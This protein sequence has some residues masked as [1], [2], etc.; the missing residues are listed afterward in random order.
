MA[1]PSTKIVT[2]ENGIQY[3]YDAETSDGI[4]QL[5]L[6]PR[7]EFIIH[8]RT[9]CW[10]SSTVKM[11]V[12]SLFQRFFNLPKSEFV[13][14][15][16]DDGSN[17]AIIA[18]SRG[19]NG[20]ILSLHLQS[21]KGVFC[22]KQYF[23]GSSSHASITAKPLVFIENNDPN[24][25]FLSYINPIARLVQ[26]AFYLCQTSTPSVDGV[27]FLQANTT[28]FKKQ[29]QANESINISYCCLVAIEES[30][31]IQT[32]EVG[33]S[34]LLFMMNIRGP[35]AVYLCTDGKKSM[36][37]TPIIRPGPGGYNGGQGGHVNPGVNGLLG[38]VQLLVMMA[39]VAVI[40]VYYPR[41]LDK[42]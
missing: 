34:S 22:N 16:N 25:Q 10:S 33:N 20:N 8:I 32:V 15:Y 42:I 21:E 11:K 27:L 36:F 26:N 4:L 12:A 23:L 40:V 13:T 28:I 3:V 35:G 24:N 29:L 7:K 2:V 37:V 9:L 17:P 14:V 6:H 39:I 19:N 5:F 1:S 41:L 18:V 30:C 38:V 31:V